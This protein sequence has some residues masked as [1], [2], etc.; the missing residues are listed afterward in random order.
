[1]QALYKIDDIESLIDNFEETYPQFKQLL[2]IDE[3][4]ACMLGEAVKRPAATPFHGDTLSDHPGCLA[5]DDWR[6]RDPERLGGLQV[7]D[8]IELDRLLDGKVSRFGALEDFVY[9]VGGASCRG[10]LA[11]TR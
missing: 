8:E 6:D 3:V 5:E 9:K 4:T 7:D 2:K 1:M 11:H 10:R